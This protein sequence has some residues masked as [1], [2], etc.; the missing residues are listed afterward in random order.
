M[1]RIYTNH[2]L[3][4]F[5]D[6][7]AIDPGRYYGDDV[8]DPLDGGEFL[9]LAGCLA[10]NMVDAYRT[11]CMGEPC[12]VCGHV[13]SGPPI[14]RSAKRRGLVHCLQCNAAS[15]DGRV[16]YYGEPVGSRWNPG[17][18]PETEAETEPKPGRKIKFVPAGSKAR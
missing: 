11:L 6:V 14:R 9:H 3:S 15:T 1:A 13:E 18:E 12:T 8:P 7:G 5:A 10:W 16:E 17:W 4:G 2:D